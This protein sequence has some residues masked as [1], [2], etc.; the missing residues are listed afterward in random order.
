M[1]KR[2][3]VFE[4]YADQEPGWEFDMP[5]YMVN[6]VLGY[7]EHGNVGAAENLVE[8]YLIDLSIKQD[9]TDA[10][11]PECTA[12]LIS[13]KS[14][15]SRAKKGTARE[16]IVYWHNTVEIDDED[17]EYYRDIVP[18]EYLDGHR[19]STKKAV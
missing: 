5:I 3:I 9:Y 7:M 15:F 1:A 18:M 10:Y 6:P 19:N 16:S 8:D 17:D 11:E 14:L 4:G 13:I 2:T 12:E